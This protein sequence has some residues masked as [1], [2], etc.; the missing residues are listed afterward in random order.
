[1]MKRVF[2]DPNHSAYG[3]V[4]RTWVILAGLGL[5]DYDS[6]YRGQHGVYWDECMAGGIDSGENEN[7]LKRMIVNRMIRIHYVLCIKSL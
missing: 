7:S 4:R 5:L 2:D 6:A 3:P 1:M